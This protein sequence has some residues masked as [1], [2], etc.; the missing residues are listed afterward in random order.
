[1]R[2]L[3]QPEAVWPS[4]FPVWLQGTGCVRTGTSCRECASGVL[5]PFL[6][7]DSGKE[8]SG[9]FGNG[10]SGITEPPTNKMGF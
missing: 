2:L 1:M 7:A 10:V 4:D 3:G 6:Q 9:S 8:L 5:L